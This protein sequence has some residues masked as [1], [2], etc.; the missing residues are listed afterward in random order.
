MKGKEY[1]DRKKIEPDIAIHYFKGRSYKDEAK[2]DMSLNEYNKAIKLNPEDCDG[3]YERAWIFHRK[4]AYKKE[5]SDWSKVLEFD[6]KKY[7][8]SHIYERR[9][10]AY[11]KLKKYE[12]AIADFSR[13]IELTDDWASPYLQRARVYDKAGE[14]EKAIADY[15]RVIKL[16][17]DRGNILLDL[18]NLQ[19]AAVYEKKGEYEKAIMDYKKAAELTKVEDVKKQINNSVEK[20][21]KKLNR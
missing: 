14:Y 19:R 3:Y 10:E 21:N 20:L 13:V 12:R 8:P 4:K 1:V 17:E 15:S 6:S 16:T 5:V 9:A 7:P 11:E 2:W 18:R